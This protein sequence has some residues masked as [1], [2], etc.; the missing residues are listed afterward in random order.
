MAAVALSVGMVIGLTPGDPG[1]QVADPGTSAP[2]TP[3]SGAVAGAHVVSGTDPKSGITAII[4]IEPVTDGTE[5]EVALYELAGAQE[6]E[7]F[8]VSRFGDRERVATWNSD[9]KSGTTVRTTGVSA[10]A[11]HDISRFE[12]HGAGTVPLL[13]VPI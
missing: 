13:V 2:Q 9:G 3:T 11:Q 12:V 10:F 6:G 7:I 8:V 5:I 4:T 1:G